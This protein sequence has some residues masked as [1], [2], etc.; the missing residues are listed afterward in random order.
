[1]THDNLK[2]EYTKSEFDE[3]KEL[4]RQKEN[5]SYSEQKGIRNKLRK[6][7]LYWNDIAKGLPYTVE[8]LEMLV[9]EGT[10]IIK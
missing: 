6:R 10:L 8:N 7:G 4:V 3:I 5:A 1:M 2:I 9:E